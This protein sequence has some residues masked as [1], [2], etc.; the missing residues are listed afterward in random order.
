M[1]HSDGA[2][3]LL[4]QST[5][6]SRFHADRIVEVDPAADGLLVAGGQVKAVPGVF[7]YDFFWVPGESPRL[8]VLEESGSIT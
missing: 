2:V 4:G 8:F 6:G 5:G 7:L 1:V 3:R